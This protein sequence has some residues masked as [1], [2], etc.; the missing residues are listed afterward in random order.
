MMDGP[1]SETTIWPSSTP[2]AFSA[3]DIEQVFEIVKKPLAERLQK[4][5]LELENLPIKDIYIPLAAWIKEKT[6]QKN[7]TFVTGLNG[8]QG[9]GKSTLSEILTIILTHG[10]NLNA[11]TF[12]IDDIYKTY[13]ERQQ[14]GET[15][16]PLFKTRGVPGTHDVELGINTIQQLC[17]ST[18]NDSIKIP[19]FLK[20]IDDRAE[21]K[22]WP[23]IQGPIDVV[24]LEGWCV[25]A[26]PEEPESLISPMNDLEQK[27]DQDAIWRTHVN[28]QLSGDYETLF[29]MLDALIM[30]KAP[31]M[32]SIFNWRKQQEDKL[33]ASIQE[34]GIS[35]NNPIRTMDDE[36]LQRFIQ[37]YERLTRFMLE[38]MPNRAN[39]T[40]M[41]DDDHQITHVVK[42][43]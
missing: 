30:L 38:E 17:S 15:L 35:S 10:F 6:Q 8:S 39:I 43:D 33:K 24:I 27:E 25:G 7:S 19:T 4:H 9:S 22:D 26:Q 16:H 1:S 23:I 2:V 41:L 11:V 14:L 29:K 28:N 18:T 21:I 13:A 32:E 12:S 40:L 31:A 3:S 34:M 5:K 20:S 42:Q 37:H 36:Q